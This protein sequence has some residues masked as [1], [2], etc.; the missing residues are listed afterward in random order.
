MLLTMLSCMASAEEGL[1]SSNTDPFIRK[2]DV[3]RLP[4]W[5]AG[6][7]A[8]GLS[9]PAYPGADERVGLVSGL[10]FI[11]YR[12][13]LLRIDRGTVGVRALKTQRTEL[14]V[15]FAAS[16][17]SHADQ[18]EA[19]RGM[20]DLGTLV[21]FGPRLKIHLGNASEGKSWSRIQIPLR[22]VFDLNDHLAYRGL[23]GELQWVADIELPD[24]WVVT[25]N[26]G[27]LYGDQM[28]ADTW[29][30]VSATEALPGRPTYDA[31]AGLIASRAS[32]L[33]SHR[34]S[35]DVRLLGYLKF[36]SV[37]GS[38]NHDSPL[39]RQEYGWT[40]GVALAWTM[41][42]SDALASE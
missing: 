7:V 19:R 29:Y 2:Y 20:A 32:L 33:V 40:L 37:T 34:Y 11:I 5:E 3:T 12:G 8:G 26:L 28:L 25:S 14:D 13:E 31:R 22:G 23:A 9:Q 38:A 27:L 4:L 42:H 21:E 39:V 15:G 41:S 6:V 1:A 17:G 16:L 10:P 30:R 18:V 35:N 36:D 24:E